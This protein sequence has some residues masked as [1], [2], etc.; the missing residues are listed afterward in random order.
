[1]KL[2]ARCKNLFGVL[3]LVAVT[4]CATTASADVNVTLDPTIRYQT[5]LGWGAASYTPP[6]VSQSLRDA[7]IREAVNE[8]GLTRLRLE[9]P[10][11]NQSDARAWEWL[12]DDWDPT[13]INWSA[14]DAAA[15]DKRVTETVIPFKEAVEANGDPFN[16]YV[17]PSFFNG[18]SSGAAPVWL[19]NNPGEYAE[20]A[21]AFLSYLK[22]AYGIEADYYCIL[23]EAGNNN[24]FNAS[25]VA[26]MIKTLGPR[27]RAAG[28][29]TKIQF[30]ESVNARTA[31][32]SYI[33]H[34]TG[35]EQMW[36]YVGCLSYHLYGTNDPYR[37]YIRDLGV[38]MGLPTAQTEYMN[39]NMNYLY[40]DLTLGGVS[41]WEIYGLGQCF[42]WN[43][44][45]TSFDRI[46]QYWNFRQVMHY[47][48]P[49][50]VR[51]EAGSSDSNLRVLA[52]THDEKITVVLI[53]GS[54][55]RLATISN[56]PAGTYAVCQSVGGAVYQEMGLQ[57]VTVPRG[58]TGAGVLSVNVPSN[59]VMTVYPHE[60]VNR[61]PTVTG[62]KADPDYLSL[63]APGRSAPSTTRLSVSATDPERDPISYA[64]SVT[65]Q[66]ADA[67]VSLTA[68]DSAT[69]SATGLTT[70]GQ[71][72]FTAA[73]SD[74]TNAVTRDVALNV[75]ADNQPPTL[76]DLHNR[77][78]VMVTLPADS[79]T[80]RCGGLDLEGD[81][82]SY[83]WSVLNQ[84]AG[85]SASL[86][87]P[88]STS[89]QA[90]N[91]NVAGDYV[92]RIELSDPTHTVSQD[93]TVTVYPEN[94]SAPV[95][96]NAAA[97]PATLTLP[98]DETSLFASTSDPDGDPISHWWSVKSAPA[99]VSPE[100]SAQGSASTTVTGLTVSGVYVFTLS[101]VDR[102]KF[103]RKD[104]SMTVLDH[105]TAGPV[106]GRRFQP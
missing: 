9:L 100:F 14:F 29:S 20:F 63:S 88:A 93:L 54:G 33:Q 53:N 74:G 22:N 69:T 7:L 87:S 52:F 67:N 13:H 36:Q 64:W 50:A 34:V 37:S 80:L 72:V 66:P 105:G 40:D 30:P 71:Y 92:F 10:S 35:D 60:G 56:L 38:S 11:G 2:S 96:L 83:H 68:P 85:A 97:S 77:L 59:A 90:S 104:V 84:P 102:T 76:V 21:L 8:L 61:P 81:L 47:V 86:G 101:V 79:T 98:A 25:V 91:M 65:S 5:I 31:W 28:L 51:I 82:L 99:G 39:L 62:F 103:A 18:G 23:N 106:A 45:D 12:N 32:N 58:R 42:Q 41:Y 89:C 95:I 17:S 78:P 75:F 46:G 6:W 24:P 73:I 43:P 26:Q 27:L 94:P 48:R 57:T 55:S 16:L 3:A 44:D 49:G 1:M 4:A 70:A 19:L 15:V